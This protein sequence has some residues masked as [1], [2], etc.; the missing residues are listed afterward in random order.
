MIEYGAM[1]LKD[2]EEVLDYL[3]S[4]HGILKLIQ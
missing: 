4:N 2:P 3:P 1:V